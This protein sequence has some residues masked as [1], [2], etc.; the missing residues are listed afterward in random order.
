MKAIKTILI[1]SAVIISLASEN[2]VAEEQNKDRTGSPDGSNTC[3]QCHTGGNYNPQLTIAVENMAGQVVTSYVPGETYTMKFFVSSIPFP[4]VYGF[5]ATALLN[6]L[7]DAGQFSSPGTGVQIEE[8][9][10]AQI[11]SRHIVEH[12]NPSFVGNYQVQWTA[13]MEP[14]NVTIYA[15]AVTANGNTE[16]EGDHG[17]N[18]SMVL[19]PAEPD[20]ILDDLIAQFQLRT[21]SDR[22]R[23]EHSLGIKADEIQLFSASGLDCSHSIEGQ[24]IRRYNLAKGIYFIRLKVNNEIRSIKILNT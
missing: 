15:A 4:T 11:P 24:E 1:L 10:T 9:N 21:F 2:G 7:S 19:S 3:V 8:V 5:Q 23:I 12:S 16:P 22:W 6:D 20:G 17:T 14:Q 13:P 18:Q